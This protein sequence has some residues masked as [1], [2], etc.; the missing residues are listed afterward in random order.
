MKWVWVT[1]WLGR[2]GQREVEYAVMYLVNRPTRLTMYHAII[3]GNPAPL[4]QRSSENQK[5][6]GS[7]VLSKNV[8]LVFPVHEIL[9]KNGGIMLIKNGGVMLI[10]NGGIMQL[11]QECVTLS[12]FLMINVSGIA[13]RM[14][15]QV[16]TH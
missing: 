4:V 6:E 14:R 15:S 12:L 8:L 13:T 10:K 7:Q 11:K 9:I 2:E 16:M 3:S 1:N 5:R